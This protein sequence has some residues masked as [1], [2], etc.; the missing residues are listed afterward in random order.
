MLFRSEE[1]FEDL[2]ARMR[3][4][5][6]DLGMIHFVDEK[7]EFARIM[8][9]EFLEYVKGLKEK[10]RIRH[11]GMST[12]NPD[13]A[14]LA[15]ESGVVEMILFSVNPAFD[16]LPAS[17]DLDEYFKEEYSE[18]IGGIAPERARL[19]QICEQQGVGITV[20][21]GYEGGRLFRAETSPFGV[22]L[23][24]IQCLHYALTRPAVEI[25]RAH[26]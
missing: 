7:A 18:D 21:K 13:V 1:A 11:I 5:Y 8:E 25:G 14:R 12:H 19:Y 10:G 16:M 6:I 4:D 3:T 20:M 15:A 26:V 2:L 23:T 24:P 17:E 22:A 9:G